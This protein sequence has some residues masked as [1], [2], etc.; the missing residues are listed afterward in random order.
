MLRDLQQGLTQTVAVKAHASQ[1][2]GCDVK[3]EGARSIIEPQR[4]CTARPLLQ[5]VHGHTHD[6]GQILS[7]GCVCEGLQWTE[8]RLDLQLAGTGQWVL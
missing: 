1:D 3:C 5:G 6:G 4:L 7:H 8:H 2:S